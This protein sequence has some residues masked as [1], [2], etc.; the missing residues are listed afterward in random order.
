MTDFTD[1]VLVAYH[2]AEQW[3][4]DKAREYRTQRDALLTALKLARE[5]LEDIPNGPEEIV[6]H[7]LRACDV[8]DAAIA[9]IET[10]QE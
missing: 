10:N 9:K 4:I 5:S 7:R 8:A 2:P 1:D 3:A 6:E